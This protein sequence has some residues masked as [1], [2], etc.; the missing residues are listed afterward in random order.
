MGAGGR[1]WALEYR[2]WF[3]EKRLKAIHVQ[4]CPARVCDQVPGSGSWC[5]AAG[6]P[7]GLCA[8]A[9]GSLSNS[10][11]PKHIGHICTAPRQ[12]SQEV[13]AGN[14]HVGEGSFLDQKRSAMAGPAGIAKLDQRGTLFCHSRKMP[15]FLL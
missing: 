8:G 2:F 9:L 6:R 15:W 12:L 14:T 3:F 13:L 5:P 7:R 10:R 1:S 4:I 11:V